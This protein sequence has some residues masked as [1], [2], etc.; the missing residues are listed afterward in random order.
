LSR[1]NDARTQSFSFEVHACEIQECVPSQVTN[2][3][4]TLV[5]L[6]IDSIILD[7]YLISLTENSHHHIVILS[8]SALMRFL[9]GFRSKAQVVVC[10]YLLTHALSQLG[11]G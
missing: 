10:M 6:Q 4:G 8:R 2:L 1:E 7:A 5:T 9:L 11:L 3:Q